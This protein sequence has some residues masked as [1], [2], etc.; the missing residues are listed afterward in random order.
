MNLTGYS[1]QLDGT[2]YIYGFICSTSF[3]RS[4]EGHY[5]FT[6]PAIFITRQ[7]EIFACI[8]IWK[9]IHFSCAIRISILNLSV[10]IV[11]TGYADA[12]SWKKKKT[13]KSQV[14]VAYLMLSRKR[15]IFA[16]LLHAGDL[17]CYHY[18]RSSVF[19]QTKNHYNLH[20]RCGTNVS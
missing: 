15:A 12:N 13:T 7:S 1:S 3:Q 10:D 16:A 19:K 4:V 14:V 18:Y 9:T 17:L 5:L 20:N 6:R 2:I 8:V 11:R